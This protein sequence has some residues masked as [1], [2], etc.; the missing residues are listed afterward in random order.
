VVLCWNANSGVL[1]G[2]GSH[3]VNVVLAAQSQISPFDNGGQ[4]MLADARASLAFKRLYGQVAELGPSA[5]ELDLLVALDMPEIRHLLRE[6]YQRG[7]G[8]RPLH[9]GI[10]LE[11]QHAHEADPSL[12]QSARLQVF[13]SGNR[14]IQ[15]APAHILDTCYLA[16]IR[17]VVKHLHQ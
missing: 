13:G 1:H 5:Q 14:R 8:D 17:D 10:A 2:C 9:G 4:F 3:I 16:R 6:I 12:R 11:G 15:A 7:L